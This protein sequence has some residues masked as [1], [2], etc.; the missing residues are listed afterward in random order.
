M[1]KICL[2]FLISIPTLSSAQFEKNIDSVINTMEFYLELYDV[3]TN[4]KVEKLSE[5]QPDRLGVKYM[6]RIP[7]MIPIEQYR[8]GK[9]ASTESF[10][11]VAPKKNIVAYD[12]NVE[13][14]HRYVCL[15]SAAMIPKKKEGLKINPQTLF[16]KFRKPTNKKDFFGNR[17]YE[18]KLSEIELTSKS[19]SLQ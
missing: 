15:F 3:K 1:K 13:E 16:L 10:E 17:A 9:F 18:D 2:L 4:K 19:F 6:L 7:N 11:F 12:T 5:V 8:F 14:D